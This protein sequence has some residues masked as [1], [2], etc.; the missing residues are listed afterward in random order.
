LTERKSKILLYGNTGRPVVTRGAAHPCQ[1][2][3]GKKE[4]TGK[5]M[6]EAQKNG[7]EGRG[8]WFEERGW[9]SSTEKQENEM[10]F[11]RHGHANREWMGKGNEGGQGTGTSRNEGLA[12]E[13]GETSC[14]G[15]RGGLFVRRKTSN[16]VKRRKRGQ[17]LRTKKRRTSCWEGE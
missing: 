6:E 17:A 4:N 15:G 10:T 5:D 2:G 8:E 7:M 3:S 11:T 14:R 16:G 1:R 9:R 13:R 12:K